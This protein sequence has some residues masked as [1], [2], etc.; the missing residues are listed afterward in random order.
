[1]PWPGGQLIARV[2]HTFMHTLRMRGRA[3]IG[4]ATALFLLIAAQAIAQWWAVA[5]NRPYEGWD[6]IATFNNASVVTGPTVGRTYRYGS[7]DTFLQ[8][9]G[10]TLYG[11]FDPEGPAYQ[12]IRYSN[13]VPQSW[14]DPFLPFHEKTWS[15]AMDYN[16]FRGVDDRQPIFLSRYLHLV[17]L[18]LVA[19][20]ICWTLFRTYRS[21]SV[22]LLAMFFLMWCAPDIWSEGSKSLPNGINAALAFGVVAFALGYCDRGHRALLLGSV[23]CLA[24]GLNFKIDMALLTPVPI[25]AILFSAGRHGARTVLRDSAAALTIFIAI[26]IATS[27]GFLVE[28]LENLL[29]HFPGHPQAL[30]HNAPD[31]RENVRSLLQF[32]GRNITFPT[33]WWEIVGVIAGL[34]AI[35]ALEAL[36]LSVQ[37]SL[38]AL[39]LLAAALVGLVWAAFIITF[40][41]IYD[42]YWFN[43]LAALCAASGMGILVMYRVGGW[44]RVFAGVLVSAVL[45]QSTAHAMVETVSGAAIMR[46]N[47]HSEGFDTGHHRNLAELAA[48]DLVRQGRFP[49]VV[50]VD[51]HSYIDLRL[52]RSHGLDARYV[53]MRSLTSAIAELDP[54]P[55]LMIFARGTYADDPYFDFLNWKNDWQS[56]LKQR[57]DEYQARLLSLSVLQRFPGPPQSVLSPQ[58][59]NAN[60]DIYVSVVGSH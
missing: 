40:P 43:G 34:L 28:P 47:A 39:I 4:I 15:G 24:L 42:R 2:T 31:F 51:Q 9:L 12:H 48:I 57:F 33:L 23:A 17:F 30:R 41:V 49:P 54:G 58:P 25:I 45:L 11:A 1:M 18:W 56:G 16:Y 20:T 32:V 59:V 19:L 29:V 27:P 13:N 52:L 26:L 6:E 22:P 38:T 3:R 46:S 35:G 60:D 55:H 53:N 21:S 10:I 8:V 7:M 37:D 14:N 36:A 5:E 44:W 50:L